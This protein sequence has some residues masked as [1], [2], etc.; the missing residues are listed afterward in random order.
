M[1]SEYIRALVYTTKA[2]PLP[3]G[4]NIIVRKLSD[5]YE[6]DI[7]DENIRALELKLRNFEYPEVYILTE[8]EN[9]KD[10]NPFQIFN[11]GILLMEEEKYW[12]AHEYFEILW[13]SQDKPASIFFHSVV[14]FCVAMV[15]HQMDREKN[16]I[17]IFNDAK[18]EIAG[19]VG[20]SI[21]NYEFSYPLNTHIITA[22]KN[23]GIKIIKSHGF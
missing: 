3:R 16:K 23:Y 17:K 18:N 8:I 7:K 13:K 11:S 20:D 9:N 2:L 22:I 4:I 14:I 6:T 5:V 1:R 10:L 21:M 19:F 15:H 12:L